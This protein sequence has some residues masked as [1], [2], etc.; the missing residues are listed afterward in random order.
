MATSRALE[1]Q[2]P[3]AHWRTI[4]T[5][6]FRVHFAPESEEVARRAAASAE[7]AYAALARELVAPRGLIELVVSDDVDFSNGYTTTFPTNRIVIYAQPPVDEGSL[8]NYSDWITLVVTHELT[9][10]FQLDRSRGGWAALQHIFGRNP[11]LFPAAYE[12]RWM[13]EG[14]AVYYESRIT[15]SGRI[16][17]TAHRAIARAAAAAG[18]SPS[19][20]SLS[21]TRTSFPGG[22]SVYIYGSLLIDELAREEG[23]PSV[24]A[25]IERSSS[26]IPFFYNRTARRQFG[27]S[28]ADLLRAVRDSARA[29]VTATGG[30]V[31][32][33]DWHERAT[34]FDLIRAPRWR[35]SSRIVF[36]GDRGRETTAAYEVDA[37]NTLHRL[38]R[39]IGVEP[40]V[41]LADGSLLTAQLEYRG[42]FEIR[43]DLYIQRGRRLQRLTNGQRLTAPDARA[44]GEIVAV[45][46][47]P[48]TTRLVRVARDGRETRPITIASLDTQWAQPRWSPHGDAIAAVRLI[49]GGR[50]QVVTIDTSAMVA[51][52]ADEQGS[53][54]A[55]PAW[56][57][58]GDS[59]YFTSD[60]SGTSEVYVAAVT[61]GP[62]VR[63]ST[64]LTA[65]SDP[66]PSR[67][68]GKPSVAAV[69]LRAD[70]V[71]LGSGTAAARP[72]SVH[73]AVAVT[74]PDTAAARRDSSPS[75][76]YRA[77]RQLV[78]RYWIPTLYTADRALVLGASTSSSDVVRRHSYGASVEASTRRNEQGGALGYA[79]AGLGQPVLQLALS[80]GWDGAGTIFASDGSPLGSLRRRT[81][82]VEGGLSATRPRTRTFFSASASG[83][84]E[85][86]DYATDPRPLLDALRTDYFRTTHRRPFAVLD[87]AGSNVQRPARSFSAEDGV[88]ASV[89]GERLWD[90]DERRG[91]HVRGIGSLAGYKSLDL[92][93]YAHHVLALRATGGWTDSEDGSDLSVGGGSGG[94]LGSTGLAIGGTRDFPVRGY[95]SGTLAGTRA[96][97]ASAEYRAPVS[98]PTS[99][100]GFLYFDRTSIAVFG[101]AATAWCGGPA[102]SAGTCESRRRPGTPIASIGAE[103][104]ADLAIAYDSPLSIGI[105]VAVPVG[106]LR[107][108]KVA[109]PG[110][111]ISAGHA[112]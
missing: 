12:P 62:A 8:R 21:T 37:T 28:F 31:P 107:S 13:T 97:S 63:V 81:R 26:A 7:W 5:P 18:R 58:D 61:G 104:I 112:F 17:G 2:R 35:D 33:D 42:P 83:G 111:Y 54:S 66:E 99:G 51:I 93:G 20:A 23:A 15:G 49:R 27:E 45:Q 86:R 24:P 30:G 60:R 106:A 4:A 56:S 65:L 102:R 110:L 91:G 105:G 19:L 32:L 98:M 57:T 36:A 74:I 29:G 82:V 87:L 71:T 53:V 94:A 10:V 73:R 92:P 46:G 84:I 40:N 67:A 6:H 100:L 39:R 108:S 16:V 75:Q 44:D 70:G 22:E 50:S 76:P 38:G 80:Q 48:G 11:F 69:W 41:P 79:W 88:T 89:S 77:A 78:P 109:T 103:F 43:S 68:M 55:A 59:V 95:S 3:D 64:A 90:P 1:A 47:E 96:V 52:V 34:G 72:D 25:F 101:D 85:L 14:I 9:H